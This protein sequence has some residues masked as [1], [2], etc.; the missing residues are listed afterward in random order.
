MRNSEGK[1]IMGVES[2]ETQESHTAQPTSHTR[3]IGRDPEDGCL[4][5]DEKQQRAE[6]EA[7]FVLSY[8]L[9]RG[10]GGPG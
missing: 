1:D 5:L 3:F 4:C 7:G 10:D 2:Q 6:Q 9:E 8:F